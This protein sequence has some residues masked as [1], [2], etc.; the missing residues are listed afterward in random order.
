MAR[1]LVPEAIRIEDEVWR[2]AFDRR[3]PD[4]RARRLRPVAESRPASPAPRKPRPAV[5][6]RRGAATASQ[7][8]PAA[9]SAST[10]AR[11]T[12][13]IRGHG[14]E[15]DLHWPT[16]RRRRAPLRP[17][18]RAG[19]RPDRVAMWAVVLCLLLLVV[20]AVSGHA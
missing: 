9:A 20:A 4:A 3:L 8:G 14:A 5:G 11:R 17:H 1:P 16:Q 15:R 7:L 18:E 19:F 12:V 13:T 6:E 2:E 10:A